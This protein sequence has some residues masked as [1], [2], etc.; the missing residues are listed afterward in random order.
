MATTNQTSYNLYFEDLEDRRLWIDGESTYSSKALKDKILSGED[1]HNSL[2][3]DRDDSIARLEKLTELSFFSKNSPDFKK[4]N[5][6]F[7]Y[8]EEYNDI[9]LENFFIEKAVERVNL[10][11]KSKREQEEII[12]RIFEELRLY[13][14]KNLIDVLRL[15]MYIIDTF[16]EQNVVW[17]PGRGSS[18]C[19]FL[20]FLI[21]IHDIDSIKFE[22]D[23][24]EFLRDD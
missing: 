23:V 12:N 4:L 8:P 20:L 13:R 16:K 7:L 10:K 17:G 21:G 14:N 24:I 6:E 22:L 9:D 2:I 3:H 11:E 15:S 19:S 18:C 1:I 5:S